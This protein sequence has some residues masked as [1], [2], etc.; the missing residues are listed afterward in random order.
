MG[1]AT[2]NF[3]RIFAKINLEIEAIMV[4]GVGVGT[5]RLLPPTPK[6][7]NDVSA[8]CVQLLPYQCTG[9]NYVDLGFIIHVHI[10]RRSKIWY[11]ETLSFGI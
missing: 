4:Q 5:F 6:S 3:L 10:F 8:L 7:L 1:E 11:H 9:A 2:C